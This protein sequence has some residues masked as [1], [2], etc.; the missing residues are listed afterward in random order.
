MIERTPRDKYE[1]IIIDNG[2]TFITGPEKTD[3]DYRQ[4][5]LN[6]LDYWD[7]ADILIRNKENLGFGPACNQGFNLARGEYIVC[8]NNDIVVWEGWE[9][10][11]INVFKQNLTPPVG[12]VMPAL[13]RE[14]RD[15]REALKLHKDQIDMRTHAGQYGVGA[16]F[17][18]L[19]MMKRDLMEKFK[20]QNNGLVF[21][22][23]F[24]CGFGEDRD[25]WKRTRLLGY[26]TYRCHDT[27]VF[28]QGNMSMSKIEDRKKYTEPNREYLK[29]KYENIQ[30]Q[31]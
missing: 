2:S 15:A 9:D 1:L 20:E 16:E 17:G 5:H 25:L 29:N 19:W 26:E 22:E 23:N 28:H 4:F 24:H 10:A 21:D 12:I 8:L 13:A 31:G 6:Q 30:R 3:V 7:Y 27:R 11:L 14:T 18:S